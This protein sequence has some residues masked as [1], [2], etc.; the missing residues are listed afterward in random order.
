[1]VFRKRNIP[2]NK[3]K[4]GI[5]SKKTLEKMSESK[6]GN[7]NPKYWLGKHI[8]ENM[9]KAISRAFTGKKHS[10]ETIKKMRGRKP[11]NYID[12]R[13]KLAGPARYGD[14]WEAIR[15]LVYL[16]DK[17]TCQGCGIKGISM[18]IHHKIPFLISRD[19]SLNNLIT[20]CRA[21]HMR[22]EKQIQNKMAVKNLW[23]I[24]IKQ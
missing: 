20:L 2:W 14:D 11:W 5:Y 15:Y 6:R 1:M 9:K 10:K 3:G 12:G 4:C 17:F 8:T 13:S 22:A 23:E 24:D 16:R 7:K 19:N 21:C 18:D